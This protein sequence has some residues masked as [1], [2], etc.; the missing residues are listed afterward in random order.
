MRPSLEL[1]KKP[2]VAQV[3]VA[4]AQ[5]IIAQGGAELPDEPERRRIERAALIIGIK[6]RL[7][8]GVAFPAEEAVGALKGL[9]EVYK[10]IVA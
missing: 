9:Q 6:S 4:L 5:R 1:L 7:G 3:I 2:H 8:A 10:K